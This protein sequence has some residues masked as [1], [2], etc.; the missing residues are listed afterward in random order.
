MTETD[1][2]VSTELISTDTLVNEEQFRE[3]VQELDD[4]ELEALAKAL[5]EAHKELMSDSDDM[6]DELDSMLDEV[7]EQHAK[8]KE[9]NEVSSL[10]VNRL[11]ALNV[12]KKIREME[13]S[14]E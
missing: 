8:V 6:L 12:R 14:E 13:A 1:D 11:M 2:Y 9:I 5:K 7:D 10:V 4:D 3:Q